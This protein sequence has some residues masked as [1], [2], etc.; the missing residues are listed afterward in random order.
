MKIFQS[1]IINIYEYKLVSIYSFRYPLKIYQNIQKRKSIPWKCLLDLFFFLL[2]YGSLCGKCFL[3]Y[4]VCEEV[5]NHIPVEKVVFKHVPVEVPVHS[6]SERKKCQLSLSS[7]VE[8]EWWDLHSVYIYKR[9]THLTRKSNQIS[10]F[11]K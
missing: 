8:F 2:N 6:S 1:L 5:V 4:P 9:S 3:P 11:K 10:C 7:M